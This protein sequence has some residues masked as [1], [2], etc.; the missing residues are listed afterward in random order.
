MGF[1]SLPSVTTMFE[2]ASAWANPI[3]QEF[4]W[5]IHLSVGIITV[6]SAIYFISSKLENGLAD[7]FEHKKKPDQQQALLHRQGWKEINQK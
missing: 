5:V 6:V 2:K 3:F 4:Q 7:M 1:D